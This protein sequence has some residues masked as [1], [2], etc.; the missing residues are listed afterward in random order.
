MPI[1]LQLHFADAKLCHP[2]RSEAQP[3]AAKDLCITAL[4]DGRARTRIDQQSEIEN[5]KSALLL[6]A[7][8]LCARL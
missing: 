7:A 6:L 8:I 2:E 5:L 3:N 1:F 4:H